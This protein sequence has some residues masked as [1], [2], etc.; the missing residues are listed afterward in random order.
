MEPVLLQ[1][2]RGEDQKKPE[3]MFAGK[4]PTGARALEGWF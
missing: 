2:E 3:A 1:R 4:F